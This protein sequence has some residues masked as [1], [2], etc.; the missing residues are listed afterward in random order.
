[1]RK[2]RR[3]KR[4]GKFISICF[5][6]ESITP[7]LLI[8]SIETSSFARGRRSDRSC[9]LLL[10]TK[11]HTSRADGCMGFYWVI[12][13]ELVFGQNQLRAGIIQL[14][15]VSELDDGSVINS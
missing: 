3:C 13:E 5:L 9:V 7:M 10:E 4:I 11:A 15:M 2:D 6:G 1:M 8:A 14:D 12:G